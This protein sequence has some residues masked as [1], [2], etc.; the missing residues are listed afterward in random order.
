MWAAVAVSFLFLVL[1][2]TIR[3]RSFNKLQFDDCLVAAAWLMLLASS[4]VWQS[5]AYIL[6]WLYD[7]VHGKTQFSMDFLDE[8]STFMPH[9]VTWNVLF[10]SCLWSIK[11]SF[12]MFFRRLRSKVERWQTIWWWVVFAITLSTWVACIA[13]IDYKCSVRS[14]IYI[15]SKCHPLLWIKNS[16]GFKSLVPDANV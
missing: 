4:I 9:I 10:Y 6:Y 3:V 1:R 11:F 15:L 5:K 7:V 12:L 16:I 8:Y 14:V 2:L 13:D